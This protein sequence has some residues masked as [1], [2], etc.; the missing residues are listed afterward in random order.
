MSPCSQRD[1]GAFCSCQPGPL[2][3][4]SR[5]DPDHARV[6]GRLVVEQR[7]ATGEMVFRSGEGNRGV[8]CLAEGMV[9]L[10]LLHD[11]GAS[12]LVDI[13][14]PGDLLGTRAFLRDTRHRT[15]AEALSDV[16]LCLIPAAEA[17]RLMHDHPALHQR[18]VRVCLDSLDASQ[19]A[20][21][22]AAA[23][24][25]RDRLFQLLSRLLQHCGCFD[26]EGALQAR[27]PISR[28]DIAGMLGVRQETLSRLLKRLKQEGLIDISGRHC[29][30]TL[31]GK[32]PAPTCERP[33]RQAIRGF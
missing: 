14:Y 30:L 32:L 6:L 10:R 25:N 29:R 21:L 1:R 8:Y 33:R 12:V 7:H 15:A 18:L 9:G 5:V 19:E 23:M 22:D 26:G 11:S 17:R 31:P 4:W 2:G 3:D 20:M 16:R 13:A 28:E 27:L 24:S